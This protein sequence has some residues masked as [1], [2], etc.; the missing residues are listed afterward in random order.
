MHEIEIYRFHLTQ[1]T[2]KQVIT[3]EAF[4]TMKKQIG[5]RYVAYQIGFNQTIL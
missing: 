2:K 5:Y 4:K 1:P 3:L